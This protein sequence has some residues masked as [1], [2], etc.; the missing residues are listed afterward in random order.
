MPTP[1]VINQYRYSDSINRR[2][3]DGKYFFDQFSVQPITAK[4]GGGAATGTA[5]DH[6]VLYTRH[7][8][9]EW[10]VIGTQTIL[11]PSLDAFGLNLVQDAAVAGDGSEVC[12]GQTA[13]CPA[14]FTIGTSAAFFM[15]CQISVQ[16]ASGINPGIIGFRKVQA[17]DATLTN[18]TDFAAIGI[19]GTANPNTIFTDTQTSVGAVHT[20]TNTT[21]TW[22]DGEAHYLTVFVDGTGNVTYQIDG[23]TPLVTVPFQF[24]NGLQV[25][26][27]I[28]QVQAADLTT[29]FSS[30][31][32]EIGFQS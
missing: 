24:A 11:A 19:E 8:T 13:L 26:P 16:D 5:G 12:I 3:W 28:R 31:W 18:Y 32:L 14:V 6:N 4:V 17:F 23:V 21:Q 15:R 29:Q 7:G 20:T 1:S 27:F 9:Y 2:Y 22:A 10:N 25:I 30:N